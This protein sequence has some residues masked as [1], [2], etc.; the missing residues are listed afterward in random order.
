MSAS[1]MTAAASAPTCAPPDPNPTKPRWRLPALSC[2]SHV[3]IFGPGDVFPYA[4]ERT[5][6]P[7]D[8]PEEKLRKLHNFLGF[9]RSVLVQSAC[10]GTDHAAVI[11]AMMQ[12]PARYR[13]VALLSATTSDAEVARLHHA[14]MR[15]VRLHLVPHLGGYPEPATIKSIVRRVAPYGWH[16]AVHVFGKDLLANLELIK[17]IEAPVVIDHMARV[18][19]REGPDGT[20]FVAL[21]RLLDRENVWVKLSGADRNSVEQPPF[22]DAVALA[23]LLAEQAP[24]R[25]VW[26]TDFPHPNVRIMPNDGMLVDLITEIAPDEATRHRMLVTNPATLFDF[27]TLEGRA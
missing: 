13:G 11:D 24:E 14:G 3:H 1:I 19:V 20:A 18:D 12:H 9:E 25:V 6:T 23:R 22:R 4:P 8:A 10:H 2:N 15:G 7:P 26:G 17:S 27:P 16:I 21:R 5:F